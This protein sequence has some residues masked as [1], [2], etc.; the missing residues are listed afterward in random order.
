MIFNSQTFQNIK[1]IREIIA[2]LVKYGFEDIVTNSTLRNFVSEK[3]RVSWTRQGQ[4]VFQ[5]TRWERIRMVC[6]ELGPTFIKLAQVL[7]NRP[8]MLPAPLIKELEKLQDNVPPFSFEEVRE[9]IESETGKRMEE[10]FSVF[11][12]KPLAT[13]SI[14]QVHKARLLNGKEVVVKIQRPGVK[15][16]V[17]RDLAILNDA[18]NR[19]DRYLKKEGI[20]N[21]M[22]MVRSFE[23]SMHKEL[24]Y[25]TESRNLERFRNLYKS[26]KNFYIPK[27]FREYS[28]EKV[29][30]M[31][32]VSGCKIS[33]V[34]QIRA[35]GLDP[36]KVAENGM[37]IYLTQIFEFGIFHAD[38]HPGNVLVRKD[39]VIC[40]LDFGMVGTLMKKDKFSFAGIFVGMAEGDPTKMAMN[41]KLLAVEDGI[42]D[43][44]QL[45]YDLNEL[46]EDF[47]S[48]DVD[49][50]SI[51]DTVERLQK[52]MFDHQIRVPG[53][54]FLIFRAFAILEGIGK[55]IHPH[56]NTYDFI[57]P[58]GFRLMKERYSP[59]NVWQDVNHRI[60][61]INSFLS[62]FPR[63]VREILSKT[64]KGKIHFEVELQ[65]YGYL[66]KKMDSI[67]NRM[68]ITFLI[69]AFIIGSAIT[70]TV[71]W[72]DRMHYIYGLPAISV[73]GL[74]TAA[75]LMLLLFYSII[76]RR[77][78]K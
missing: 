27:S 38:P 50:A 19:T 47:A 45:E 30:V 71:D 70:M 23:R 74:W 46:I 57:R 37:E 78:Y 65:G 43:M 67:A 33:D 63:D 49:E 44:R 15:D 58:Y 6:E 32:F 55:T 36:R 22:D 21:A 24:D 72:G 62:S 14:G 41:M 35:W 75:G 53:D 16:M 61:Q 1:R 18:V 5:Y 56:F 25:R 11:N 48:L 60:T 77:K 3:G 20:L 39:G 76:R 2:V 13:A 66:L 42:K 29:M 7:S 40:L 54:I 26:Y 64:K 4:P 52:I 69:V 51:A 9:S 10:I 17:Y 34:A 12:E 28:S 73:Y 8:D 31:E 68:A 59:K